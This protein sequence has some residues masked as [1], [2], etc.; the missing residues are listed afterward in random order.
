MTTSAKTR[1]YP[2]KDTE[3]TTRNRDEDI[4]G[5]RVVDE[6]GDE[7]GDVD[8]LLIDDDE[9]KVRFIRVASGG[10]LGLGKSKVL[11]PVEAIARI[12]DDEVR[13][14]QRRDR[15]FGAPPYDPE[16]VDEQYYNSLYGYYGLSPF[17]MPGYVY[18]P[19]PRYPP[20]V[21]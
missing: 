7:I 9:N 5:R 18:P 12:E 14:D 2:L 6:N 15:I 10:F 21:R 17:W 19:Y 8:D 16:L 13:I 11:I 3:L 20:Q 1:F 4:R